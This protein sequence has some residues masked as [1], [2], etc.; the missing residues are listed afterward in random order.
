MQVKLKGIVVKESIT[1][2]YSKCIDLL[3]DERGLIR[4]YANG[5]RGSKNRHLSSTQIFAYSEFVLY[6]GKAGYI[7]NE[8]QIIETFSPLATDIKKLS[9][10]QYFCEIITRIAPKEEKSFDL[11]RLLLNCLYYLQNDIKNELLIKSIFEMRSCTMA[12]YMPN[13]VGCYKCG[14]YKNEN[15]YFSLQDSILVCNDCYD[16]TKKTYSDLS[17]IDKAVLEALRHIVYCE[18]LQ[19]FSFNLSEGYL[20]SLQKITEKYLLFHCCGEFK[21]LAIYNSLK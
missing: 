5:G 12:G 10:A 6:K 13:F 16:Y 17:H 8:S 7:I 2:E 1:S 14:I 3:T 19:I 4:A 20:Q 9:L 18:F 15:M 21:S 11:L